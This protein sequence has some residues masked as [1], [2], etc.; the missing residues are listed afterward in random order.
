M[1]VLR[2]DL[3]GRKT[4]EARAMTAENPPDTKLRCVV[5]TLINIKIF[6]KLENILSIENISD[7]GLL[8]WILTLITLET[9]QLAAAKRQSPTPMK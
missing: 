5:V 9:A 2:P 4:V 3:L 1:R 7:L 8:F 6:Q